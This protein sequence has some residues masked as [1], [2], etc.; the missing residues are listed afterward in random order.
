LLGWKVSYRT[1]RG[2][3]PEKTSRD[4]DFMHWYLFKD[5]SFAG[6]HVHSAVDGAGKALFGKGVSIPVGD[7]YVDVAKK[8][9]MTDRLYSI[10]RQLVLSKKMSTILAS[11][12]IC[13]GIHSVPVQVR[14]QSKTIDEYYVWY[15]EEALDV[16]DHGA[17]NIEYFN[18]HVLSVR[19]WVL[20]ASS[21]PDC[22]LFKAIPIAWIINQTLVDKFTAE[23]VTGCKF[24][25]LATT[26]AFNRRF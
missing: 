8:G 6:C 10:G 21:I 3:S 7:C 15:A 11:S 12:H 25:R 19:E 23:G 2:G 14:F 13:R 24:T 1:H 17:A 16:L 26:G 5:D 4:T 20:L 22:D 9:K 18:G